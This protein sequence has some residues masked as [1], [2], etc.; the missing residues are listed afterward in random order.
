MP[1]D[2][3]LFHEPVSR[4]AMSIH[5]RGLL[6]SS[7]SVGLS[8]LIPAAVHARPH[9]DTFGAVLDTLLPADAF[10]PAATSLGVDKDIL[11]IVSKNELLTRLFDAAL[12]WLDQVEA[13]PFANLPSKRQA[14]ILQNMQAADFNQIPGRFFHIIR[15][16]AVEFYYAK[17]EAIAG[18][19]LNAAPQPEGY[20]P[21]WG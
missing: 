1:R 6:L 4:P 15:A 9:P 7:L 19:P 11:E 16:L 5:R 8:A 13:E 21:P 17:P 20:L 12:G 18:F 3:D 10:S 2:R 14:E